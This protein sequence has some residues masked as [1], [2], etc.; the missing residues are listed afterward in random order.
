MV[1]APTRR[2][3]VVFFGTPEFAVPTLQALLDSA[4]DVVGVVTQPDRPRGR[5]QQVLA[6]PVKQLAV[7]AGVPVLQPERMK[8]PAF[9]SAYHAWQPDLGVV[10][11][12]G[13]ILP[14][15]VLDTPSLGLINV[16][17]SLL[18]RHRGAAPVHRAVIAGDVVTGVSIM[19]VV[20]ALDAGPVFATVTRPIGP[21]DTSPQ[22]EGDLA[23][24][25]ARLLVDVADALADG[26]AS[27]TPQDDAG[28]TYAH[29]LE[30]PEGALDWSLPAQV[31]HNRVRG[32]Q[33]WPMVWT[34]LHDHRV[35]LVGTRQVAEIVADDRAP[36]TVLAVSRDALRVRTVDGA[37]DI[38]TVQPEGRRPMPARDF[39]A[40]HRLSAGDRFA[41]LGLGA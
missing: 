27:S 14:Q 12:Y 37:I 33:P 35:I 3:R 10:A 8:D 22:V 11:A 19:G 9:Q 32:L 36:G 38:L 18:P 39:A 34:H 23:V 5:G 24:L 29:R 6:S 16:H 1:M 26:T 31:I 4:H 25:G 41:T 15:T 21:D 28:A 7:S 30:K 2:L 13:R 17:A 40:G 20:L